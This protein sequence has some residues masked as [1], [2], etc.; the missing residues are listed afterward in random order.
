[1]QTREALQF[2]SRCEAGLAGADRG[3]AV[4]VPFYITDSYRDLIKIIE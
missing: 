1:M 3:E 2:C 4:S